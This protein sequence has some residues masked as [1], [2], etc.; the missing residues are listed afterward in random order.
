MQPMPDD[1][2]RDFYGY[3]ATP[4]DPRWPGGARIAININLN[5]EAGGEHCLLEGDSGSEDD[6]D[7]YRLSGL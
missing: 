5:F 1:T 3:G 6:A 4:P 2:E 7:R